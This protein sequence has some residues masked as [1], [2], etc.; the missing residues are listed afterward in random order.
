MAEEMVEGEDLEKGV[1][2]EETTSP[3][4]NDA[5]TDNLPTFD[6][7]LPHVTMVHGID[8]TGLVREKR[9]SVPPSSSDDTGTKV[10]RRSPRAK[11]PQ[12]DATSP[13]LP[14]VFS[15]NKASR[16]N[17][18]SA[19]LK[20]EE[21]RMSDNEGRF[22]R[23]PGAHRSFE[24]TSRESR[25]T[26]RSTNATRGSD[27]SGGGNEVGAQR[28]SSGTT[29]SRE[30][31][32]TQRNT[33]ASRAGGSTAGGNEL[34]AQSVSSGTTAALSREKRKTQRN[35]TA[36]RGISTA[37]S[38]DEDAPG[39]HRVSSGIAPTRQEPRTI[40]H[41]RHTNSTQDNTATSSEVMST[42]SGSSFWSPP[43]REAVETA[44]LDH[45]SD[46]NVA[47]RSSVPELEAE[48]VDDTEVERLRQENQ[49]IKAKQR[50]QGDIALVVAEDATEPNYT[51]QIIL[52]AVCLM[53]VIAGS[54]TG[55]VIYENSLDP[56]CTDL[57]AKEI[58]LSDVSKLHEEAFA[59][60]SKNDTWLPSIDCADASD[61]FLERY[62]LAVLYFD[63]QGQNW[64]TNNEGWLEARSVCQW[65]QIVCD[66]AQ[67][68][69]E[70]DSVEKNFVGTIPTELGLL[71]SLTR[72]NFDLNKL[73]GTLPTEIGRWTALKGFFF[74]KNNLSGPIPTTVGLITS[75]TR[76][77]LIE[78][79][80]SGT[81]PTEFGLLTAATRLIMH[82]NNYTGPLPS[83]VGQLTSLNRLEFFKNSLS[84]QLPSEVGRLSDLERLLLFKNAFSGSLPSEI[85]L[86]AGM[87]RVEL[88]DNSFSGTLPSQVGELTQMTRLDLHNNSMV[89]SLPTDLLRVSTLRE[90]MIA[91]NEFTGSIPPLSYNKEICELAPLGETGNCF[92]NLANRQDCEIEGNCP[93][94]DMEILLADYAPLNERAVAWLRNDTWAPP[95]WSTDRKT[96]YLQR[97]VLASLYFDTDGDN[98]FNEGNW[99]G[100]LSVCDWHRILCNTMEHV[101]FVDLV[102]SNLR[103]SIP[104]A[105][106]M[107]QTLTRL[108]LDNNELVGTIPSELGM[109]NNVT[110]MFMHGNK[111]AGTIPTQLG[112]LTA[113]T[114]LNLARNKGLSGTLPTEF[115]MLTSCTRIM[116]FS[117]SLSG[118][119]PTN[120][121]ALS[122]LKQLELNNNSFTGPLPEGIE[123]LTSLT[124]LDVGNNRLYGSVPFL[125]IHLKTCELA[126]VGETGNCFCTEA[127]STTG[128]NVEGNCPSRH[129]NGTIGCNIG[130]NTTTGVNS[131]IG[132][133]IGGNCTTS[134]NTT[135]GC[136]IGVNCTTILNSTV[137]CN[138]SGNCTMGL[139]TTIG[140]DIPVNCTTGLNSQVVCLCDRSK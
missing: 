106:G 71:T 107:L 119:I 38:E 83:E 114:R 41:S 110:G 60:I 91:N 128:C 7:E 129:L 55:S 3:K 21:A 74:A 37:G 131:T 22:N 46:G 2:S 66:N 108:N 54:V 45:E 9:I 95:H 39:A 50:Q 48:A 89:G 138:V 86:L 115:G 121:L 122:H 69:I 4:K 109:L 8:M 87:I 80:L 18:S 20:D 43:S 28:I 140:C 130:G 1:E 100:S 125:P 17:T 65:Q 13:V 16:K 84:G 53:I 63:T 59:W 111:L 132:C 124:S 103:G 25:K 15:S 117:N 134:F 96:Y 82:D 70:I 133:N 79:R 34:G 75:L 90:F 31:R 135:I 58:L 52:C 98:W 5:A 116:L 139:N 123:S 10:A 136:D 113:L 14:G 36:T 29:V 56:T 67:H 62:A 81:I 57:P 61:F 104:T 72:I 47:G 26:Q 126:P 105:L 30:E 78:N 12:P 24:Q 77:N 33:N 35:T 112:A 19:L 93:A 127:N 97:Y 68:V 137:G 120:I 44:P 118:T 94:L 101:V 88:Y 23:I 6:T 40:G 51:R 85:G 27:S 102:A 42:D 32:K 99:M 11:G 49:A 64:F 92:S 73:T 76:L